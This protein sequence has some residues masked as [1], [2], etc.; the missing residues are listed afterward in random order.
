M[1]FTPLKR[2]VL[3][4][5][6]LILWV[7]GI[8]VWAGEE[9][10]VKGRVVNIRQGPGTS[11]QVVTQ[12]KSG[13]VLAVLD[14]S[15]SWL[16]IQ[17][18]SGK[19]GW[20]HKDLVTVR[21][22]AAAVNGSS[23]Q[24]YLQVTTKVLNVRSGPG[25]GYKMVTKI[26]LNEKHAIVDLKDGWYKIQVGTQQGWVSGNYVKVLAPA[27][28]TPTTP[29]QTPSQDLPKSVIITGDIVNIRQQGSLESAVIS[30]VY[31][32][33]S[34]AVISKQN[35][36]YQ[37]E[38]ASQAR[39]WVAGWLVEPSAESVPAR[40]DSADNEVLSAPLADQK[41][42]SITERGN[43]PV[44]NLEGWTKD[45][46]QVTTDSSNKTVVLT[47]DGSTKIN[48]EGKIER[49]GILDLKIYAR[50]NK[51]VIEIKSTFIPALDTTY[52][53]AKKKT[54]MVLNIGTSKGLTGKVIVVDPGHASVQP[55]GWLDPGAIGPRTNLYEKDVT[56]RIAVNLKNMLEA[57]GA[58]VIMT[59][60][61]QTELSLAGRAAIANNSQADIF[62]SIHAN[63]STQGLS[64]HTTYFY[65][66][67]GDEFL[68]AQRSDRQKLAT[69]VQNELVKTVGRKDMGVRE[70][71]FAV[72][73]ET[74]V[75]SILVETA[76]IS[77]SQEEILLG[78]E[79][80][81]QKLAV[82]IFRGIQSYFE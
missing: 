51:A 65:A 3:C 60:L 54:V 24:K 17:L 61:G 73:R 45:Q 52:D 12:V 39:G 15:G 9:G 49:L 75:P 46:I 8:P 7:F 28:N 22:T 80:F 72:L 38:L 63:S 57:A 20:V 76:F 59:H 27:S 74:R 30:K 18:S 44:L 68:A 41:R 19:A 56:L 6:I 82:G 4:C 23:E 77:D 69:L 21:Q 55:G 35:D 42:F 33:Q 71:N 50:D 14:S 10:V 58:K 78:D 66:P 47:L 70:S 16:K 37:V 25:T 40:G 5:L 26:G 11:Y 13:Q 43:R 29:V 67:W 48:Y 62:V 79:G 1:K 34:L 36:W 2:W 64:G 32:G 53:D 81:R 31:K